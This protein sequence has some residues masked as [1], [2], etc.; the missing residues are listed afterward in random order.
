[1]KYI[2][3][4]ISF[5][6][7]SSGSNAQTDGNIPPV[8]ARFKGKIISKGGK[9]YIRLTWAEK[10]SSDTLTYGYHIYN[11]FPPE[12]D[13]YQN[14]RINL[15]TTNQYD[16]EIKRPF[17]STYRFAITAV[18]AYPDKVESKR[19]DIIEIQTPSTTL[20]LVKITDYSLS[21]STASVSWNY[22]Q[23]SDLDQFVITLNGKKKIIQAGADKR[24]V[25]FE[26]PETIKKPYFQI[27]AISKGG[28][29]SSKSTIKF[30]S[31]PKS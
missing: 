18:S 3:C 8:P 20:P 16:Y 9:D 26:V 5:L 29:E 25:K 1:M 12:A 4:V 31:L 24:S 21:G 7:L 2:L 6:V 11:N 10:S 19:S 23:I 14:G 17:A 13:L 15:L 30:L 28:V 27:Q 22:P